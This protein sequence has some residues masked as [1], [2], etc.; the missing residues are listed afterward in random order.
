[1]KA[2]REMDALR[3]ARGFLPQLVVGIV[4]VNHISKPTG[5]ARERLSVELIETAESN[6][7]I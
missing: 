3:R 5:D 6:D 2:E 1:M 7:S 4:V